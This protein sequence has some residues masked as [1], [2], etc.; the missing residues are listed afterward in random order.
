MFAFLSAGIVY[1]LSAGL[2]PGPLQALV[3]SQTLRHGAKEGVRV[4]FA[5]LITDLPIILLSIFALTRLA[6][7]QALLGLV[8]IAGGLYVVFL[9]YESFRTGSLDETVGTAA[10]KSISKGA[11]VNVLNPHPYLFWLTVGGPYIVQAWAATPLAAAAFLSGFYTCIVGSKVLLAVLAGKSRR[12]L[13]GKVYQYVMRGLGVL[14]LVFAFLL[15]EDG[16]ELLR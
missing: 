5:P 9:A 4:A 15:L 12:L 7:S 3:I 10:P 1:G 11:T 2:S 6:H 14:L 13:S 16:C 8:S